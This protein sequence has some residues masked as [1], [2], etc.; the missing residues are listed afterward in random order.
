[1]SGL[2]PVYTDEI[3]RC[4]CDEHRRERCDECCLA[5]GPTN[6]MAEV[7]AG[8]SAPPSRAQELAEQKVMIERGIVY[9]RQNSP[10]NHE[11]I[12]HHQ[13]MLAEVDRELKDLERQGQ[14]V[15]IAQAMAEEVD[16]A[17]TQD[18][19]LAAM[20]RGFAQMNPGQRHF[21]VGGPQTQEVYE[22]YVA[23]PPSAQRDQSVD[24]F[25]CSY[26]HRLS[27][28]KLQACGRCKKQAYCSRECQRTHWKA[29]KKECVP[30]EE[31]DRKD[32]KRLPLTWK[33]L[34]EFGVA[35]QD[36]KL[37]VRFLEQEPGMR[38]IALC[39]DRVGIA[40]RVA[41]YTNSRTIP[42]L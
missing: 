37:E 32:Q 24:P 15:E 9:V 17:R 3:G 31:L 4:Y 23:P 25:T 1:M 7:R 19:E 18:A 30:V 28:T 34:E 16:K 20:A 40:K 39:K 21:E 2:S 29:H 6:R 36:R 11:Y 14:E 38:L 10:D 12:R 35:P 5:F 27:T 42:G 8:L 13:Q 22:Q 26:C 41:A 33:Q